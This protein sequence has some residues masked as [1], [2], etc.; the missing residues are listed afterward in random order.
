MLKQARYNET[1]CVRPSSENAT[2]S[3]FER[4]EIIPSRIVLLLEMSEM[5][6]ENNTS[7]TFLDLTVELDLIVSWVPTEKREVTVRLVVILAVSS[8]KS[9]V[10]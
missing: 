10:N 8:F 9:T 5:D 2:I 6:P 4:E 1:R 7:L 3:F